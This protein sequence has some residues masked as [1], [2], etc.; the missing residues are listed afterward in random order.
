MSSKN[1]PFFQTQ[2]Y[3]LVLLIHANQNNGKINVSY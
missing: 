3:N 2:T 1:P